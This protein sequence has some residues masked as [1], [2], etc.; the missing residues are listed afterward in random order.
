MRT[1]KN[2]FN[3]KQEERQNPY[4]GFMSFQHFNSETLYSDSVVDINGDLT[5]TEPFEC[6][7]IPDDVPQNGRS[8]GFYPETSIAYIRILWKEFEPE[9]GKFNYALIENLI[10]NAKANNHTLIF[11][12]MPHSTRECDDVPDWLKEMIP[13]PERPKGKRVK[14]SPKAP[15]FLDYFCRAITML[16]KRFDNEPFFD[17][18]DISLTGAWGE[19]YQLD[20]YPQEAVSKLINTYVDVFKH[21]QLLSQLIETD[22]LIELNKKVNVGWRGDGLG[23]PAH[24]EQ[25][26]PPC[27]ERVPN[28]WKKVPV[29]FE[30]YWWL[31]EWK[32]QGWDIDKIIETTLNWHV[33]SINAKSLPIPYE[34]KDKIDYW[35]SKMGYHF[36]PTY[37][38]FPDTLRK[39]ESET[40]EIEIKNYGVAPIYKKLPFVLRFVSGT[41]AFEVNTDTDITDW[42]PGITNFSVNVTIP[43]NVK[44][45]EY[46]IEIGIIDTNGFVIYMCTDAV[47]DGKFYKVGKF[48]IK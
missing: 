40:V 42:L 5:E 29:S 1:I 27:I 2:S 38:S 23:S 32:R 26:Y 44:V 7:P 13:C 17:S 10:E 28:L 19:G 12:L 45:G 34:W 30:S 11:R 15:E 25:R 36:A 14:E 33:S 39:G 9:F 22:R 4:I 31:G 16:G 46:D 47:R 8:E 20:E 41:E 21:T 35:I 24:I 43:E 37:V 48:S 3:Y 6:Y 18:I